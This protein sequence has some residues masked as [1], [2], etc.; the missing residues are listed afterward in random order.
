[1]HVELWIFHDATRYNY[2]AGDLQLGEQSLISSRKTLDCT[3]M[4][5]LTLY[6]LLFLSSNKTQRFYRVLGV[7]TWSILRLE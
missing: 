3:F 1:M 2:E 7:L 4:S 6:R 5:F